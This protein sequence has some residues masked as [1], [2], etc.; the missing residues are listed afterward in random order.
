MS[1]LVYLLVTIFYAGVLW[2]LIESTFHQWVKYRNAEFIRDYKWI[3]LEIKL[4]REINKSP[5]AMEAV[6]EA[7]QQGGGLR[8]WW[9][10]YRKGNMLSWFSLEIA[11]FGGDIHFF[12]RTHE[13]FKN[14][15]ESY[16]YAQYPGIEIF[17]VED[18][19]DSFRYDP[20]EHEILGGHFVLEKE[21]YMPVK[22]YVDYGLDKDPK[23][24]FKTD[25]ITPMLEFMGSLKGNQQLWYQILIRSDRF[26]DWK[27]EAKD[28]VAKRFMRVPKEGKEEDAKL[29][30][31][32]KL[33][34]GEKDEIRAIER[35]TTKAGFEVFIQALYM[36]PHSE[37]DSN[38]TSSFVGMLKPFGSPA[39]NSFRVQEDT[40]FVFPWQD[41]ADGRKLIRLKQK[42]FKR[43]VLRMYSQYWSTIDAFS[44]SYE[45]NSRI[46]RFLRHGHNYF[47][48]P[49]NKDSFILNIEELATM[50]H[51]PGKV[52]GTPTFKRISSTKSEAP[53]NLPV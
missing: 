21:D 38:K 36:A 37:T 11:S 12:I 51:F 47:S 10:R 7:F 31:E 46:D 41:R 14:I 20:K 35:S 39:F 26:V 3:T 44:L 52:A 19:T 6:L 28:E 33:T 24:E 49:K 45:I 50:Y 9:D 30:T 16:I 27:K 4:P 5:A 1:T 34:Q 22:T 17:E 8:T 48:A 53:S 43:F 18:Y 40:S 2:V 15:I 13:K 23:E 42:F 32:H 25:P 29:F